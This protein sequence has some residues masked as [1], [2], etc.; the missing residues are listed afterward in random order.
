LKE[1]K[2]AEEKLRE[3]IK[4]YEIVIREEHPRTLKSQYGLTPLSW[5]AGNGYDTVGKA[6]TCERWYR[7]G[8]EG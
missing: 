2:E 8:L 3:A 6:T 1:Y 5:A 4:G 7:T